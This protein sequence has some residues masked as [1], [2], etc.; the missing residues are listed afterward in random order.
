MP[1]TARKFPDMSAPIQLVITPLYA[2][3]R[4]TRAVAAGLAKFLPS[5]PKSI[6][7]MTIANTPPMTGIY[8]GARGGRFS[9]KISPV[10]SAEKSKVNGFLRMRL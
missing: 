5:P 3:S 2:S 4:N 6:F 7:T 1:S 10:T 8:H 9:P